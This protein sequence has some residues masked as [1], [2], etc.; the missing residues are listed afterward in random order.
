MNHTYIFDNT[1]HFCTLNFFTVYNNGCFIGTSKFYCK[2][3]LQWYI[4]IQTVNRT[5]QRFGAKQPTFKNIINDNL[6]TF[7]SYS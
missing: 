4:N 2:K 1:E 3:V 6:T 7:I 5:A